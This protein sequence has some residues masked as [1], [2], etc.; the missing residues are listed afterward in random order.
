[1]E[2]KVWGKNWGW[3]VV[4]CLWRYRRQCCAAMYVGLTGLATGLPLY[5]CCRPTFSSSMRSI[6]DRLQTHISP[7][8]FLRMPAP[9]AFSCAPGFDCTRLDGLQPTADV[10]L[11]ITRRTPGLGRMPPTTMLLCPTPHYAVTV[12]SAPADRT[13]STAAGCGGN[14]SWMPTKSSS[15]AELRLKAQQHAAMLGMRW[16]NNHIRRLS[17][18]AVSLH[19]KHIT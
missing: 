2:G 13:L 18:R 9:T 5:A 12:A 4:C 7:P 19:R 14:N 1:M 15:I 17:V 6:F 11:D 3:S 10:G 8:H 16:Q